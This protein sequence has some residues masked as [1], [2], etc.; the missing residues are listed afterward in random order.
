MKVN[1]EVYYMKLVYVAVFILSFLVGGIF[2]Y[3]SPMEYKTVVVYP[4]PSNLERIQYKDNAD[5]CFQFSARLVDC[6]ND[7]KKI[8][9]Q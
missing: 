3:L 2:L 9:V 8:P 6:G 4:T 7:A 1:F 5:N